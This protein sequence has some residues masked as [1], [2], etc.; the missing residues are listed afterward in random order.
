MHPA[1]VRKS[2]RSGARKQAFPVGQTP[3][4][5]MRSAMSRQCTNVG[6]HYRASSAA[7]GT[8][9]RT[10]HFWLGLRPVRPMTADFHRLMFDTEGI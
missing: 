1:V 7:D 8:A 9:R 3:R 4:S 10:G 6:S 2:V 5:A